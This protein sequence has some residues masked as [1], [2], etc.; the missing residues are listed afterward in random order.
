L[1]A[2]LEGTISFSISTSTST[3][4]HDFIGTKWTDR[5]KKTETNIHIHGFVLFSFFFQ[6]HF[7]FHLGDTFHFTK[8][9]L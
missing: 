3:A 9:K 7:F 5:E 1:F 8:Q 2:G 4:I 6:R